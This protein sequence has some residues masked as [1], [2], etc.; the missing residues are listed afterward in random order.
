MF[1]LA[2]VL[3]FASN[4]LT[5]EKQY[6]RIHIRANSNSSQDQEV[7]Y[8]V[9]DEVVDAL[10]PIL[11]EVE[12]F[13]EAKEVIAE[14]FD[15]IEKTANRVLMENG[16]DYLSN[17]VLKKEQFPTRQYGDLVLE[18]GKYD[19]LILNLGS[20]EGDNWW[21]LIYPAFCFTSSKNSTNIEYISKILEIIEYIKHN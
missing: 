19:A 6:L 13:E 14:N 21:C 8:K 20:G 2:F 11:S 1:V 5:E 3:I 4:S 7:K 16:F 17:A 9:R 10:I 12:T 18:S 15:L